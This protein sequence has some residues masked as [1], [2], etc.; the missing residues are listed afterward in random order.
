MTYQLQLPDQ[1]QIHPVF[2]VDLLTPYKE[3][4]TYGSNYTRPPPDLINGEEEY[5]V[6]RVIDSRQFG[7]GRQVQYLVKWKGY[8]NSDNQWLKWQDINPSDL[9]AEYQRENPDA[10]THIRRG[11]THETIPPPSSLSTILNLVAPHCASMSDESYAPT[12]STTQARGCHIALYD[13]A[14]AQVDDPTDGA[15]ILQR[16]MDLTQN[17]T[18]SG[19][20][21]DGQGTSDDSNRDVRA[22]ANAAS[23]FNQTRMNL[24]ETNSPA[25]ICHAPSATTTKKPGTR[26]DVIPIDVDALEP[27]SP[28]SPIY[29][30]ALD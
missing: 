14:T 29:V 26:G 16:V 12:G 15:A 10:I 8:P 19:V 23:K 13:T 4:A 3:T 27:G 2:H 5:E 30:D 11:W 9:I 22:D 20:T 21:E 28:K 7:R 25:R 24:G 6:E 1:W 18:T 17:P